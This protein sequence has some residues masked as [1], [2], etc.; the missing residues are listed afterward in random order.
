MADEPKPKRTRKPKEPEAT[1]EETMAEQAPP[2]PTPEPEPQVELAAQTLEPAGVATLSAGNGAQ[3]TPFAV[4]GTGTP[5]T[6]PVFG[7]PRFS[8]SDPADF[9][10]QAKHIAD[11]IPGAKLV[12]IPNVGHVPHL[13][14]PDIFEREI[15][16]FLNE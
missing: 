12:L 14:V 6:S 16:K 8:A 13:E 10:T 7:V 9:P 3:V 5:P 11:T 1:P 15:L 2:E 4:T